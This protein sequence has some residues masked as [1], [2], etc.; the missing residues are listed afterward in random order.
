MYERLARLASSV[1]PRFVSDPE[2]PAFFRR[3]DVVV[4]PYR[5]IDQSGVLFTAM[6]FGRA[7][8]LSACVQMPSLSAIP[9]V[10]K[11]CGIPVVSAAVCTT[12]QMLQRLGLKT[13]VPNAGSLLS[14]KFQQ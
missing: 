13:H 3:A 9:V 11:E 5:E 10:E 4:L 2:I 8:V 14:G 12:H 7:V 6:A 1:V